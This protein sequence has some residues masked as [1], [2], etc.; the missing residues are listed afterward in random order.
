MTT[1]IDAGSQVSGKLPLANGGTNV[2]LSA[3]G[4]ATAVLAQDGSHVISARVLIAADIPNLD[5]SKITTG[6][7]ALARG[8]T[9]ADLSAT[10]G[11]SQFLK[12][13][14]V[15]ADV[16]VAQPAFSDISGSLAGSQMPTSLETAG[17]GYFHAFWG[18]APP[19]GGGSAFVLGANKFVFG[20]QIVFP[21]TVR[22]ISFQT[23]TGQAA[24]KIYVAVYD[25]GGT[26]ITNSSNGG[27][28]STAS[29]TVITTTLG[30][31]FTLNPGFYYVFI[32][33]DTA[34]LSVQSVNF[35]NAAE[36][37]MN[38]NVTRLASPANGVSGAAVPGTLGALTVN[39]AL[40]VI[41]ILLES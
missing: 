40:P 23:V 16:T 5:A 10:G 18:M 1:K 13:A 24:S 12:Q 4:S 21:I 32:Q 11:T 15:G 25:S 34:G 37:V 8:G 17:I 6:A 27:A 2:D 9:H 31:P 41:Q 20:T 33:G 39:S 14:S 29:N 26:L 28:T 38:Q 22:K 30:T 19:A 3:S 36:A 7:L 35:S